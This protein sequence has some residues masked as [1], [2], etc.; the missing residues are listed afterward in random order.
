MLIPILLA[1]LA[2]EPADPGT[3]L[4]R[5]HRAADAALIAGEWETA[6]SYFTRGLGLAAESATLAYGMA[7]AAVGMEQPDVALDWL[8]RAVEWGYVDAELAEWDQ[9]LVALREHPRFVAAMASMRDGRELAH[10][11]FAEPA[12]VS[13]VVKIATIAAVD[14][15]A[16][17]VAAGYDDG[18]VSLLD[19]RTGGRLRTWDGSGPGVQALAF[20]PSGDALAV[21]TLNGLLTMRRVDSDERSFQ[22]TAM[23]EDTRNESRAEMFGDDEWLDTWI[24]T[25]SVFLE[26]APDGEHVAALVGHLGGSIWTKTGELVHRWE[27]PMG[28]H[29]HVPVSWSPGGDE[30]ATIEDGLV[31]FRSIRSDDPARAPLSP[32]AVPIDVDYHPDGGSIVTADTDS[33]V[34]AWNLKSGEMIWESTFQDPDPFP[35]GDAGPCEVSF[36]P[37][38]TLVAYS[39]SVV[40]YVVVL[41]SATG[42]EVWAS[43]RLGG[44]MGE[45]VG[46]RWRPDGRK[47]WFA[48]VSGPMQLWSVEPTGARKEEQIGSGPPPSVSPGGLATFA[49]CGIEVVDTE[50]DRM[51]WHRTELENGYVLQG[52][53]GH[54][55]CDLQSVSNIAFTLTEDAGETPL[56]SLIRERFD[57]KRLRAERAGIAVV[58]VQ[59][60]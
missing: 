53:S 54:F 28:S 39:T 16:T 57:P 20:S 33:K 49:W 58:P 40:A 55:D 56:S 41:D 18:S 1:V 6:R 37:D 44:R 50:T 19:A 51:L 24:P 15:A 52:P 31:V 7:A 46:L 34:R 21:L 9:D 25:M 59:Q 47:L 23:P 29:F 32:S 3:E 60:N 35:G 17:V 42:N 2:Q 12:Y 26:F 27:E 45:R 22:T 4:M 48:F 10:S 13:P 38:G 5:V 14:M 36:S 8:D 43:Q 30:L 11:I